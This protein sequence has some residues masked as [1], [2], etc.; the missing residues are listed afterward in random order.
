[1]N[2][3]FLSH[4]SIEAYFKQSKNDFVVDEVPLYEFSGEGEHLILKIRKKDLTTWDMV[5][6]ISNHIGIRN[7]EIGYAGLK[8]K[9]ALTVQHISIPK[10]Y[11]DKIDNFEH[12]QIKIIDKTYHNNKIRIGH[13][14]GN[15]FFI[16]LKRVIGLHKTKI[17]QALEQIAK[18][19]IPN[20]FGYQRFGIDKKNYLLG[21][22]I[23]SGK[24]KIR[25]RKKREF[26]ISAYQSYLFNKWLSKRVE[27][28]KIFTSFSEKE[29]L[30]YF[31]LNNILE[32]ISLSEIKNIKKQPHP[33]KLFDGD[34]MHHY[35][36]G[37]IFNLENLE[38][39]SKRF[40]ERDI[41]PTGLLSGKKVKI[42]SGLAFEFEKSFDKELK[43]TDGA[44]RLA[45]IYPE[46]IKTNYK[47]QN[48]W[49]EI[50]FYLPK[51]SYATTVLEEILHKELC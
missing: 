44:R 46:E 41:V 25:D 27:I 15:K 51:G 31:K 19:G 32:N 11:E 34:I 22:E 36:Y 4:S 40:I 42:S 21:E 47:E 1:M 8:D 12:S 23:E 17:E 18:F 24:L 2:Q 10:I 16:R 45:W 49:L 43:S 7:R 3:Y 28:S 13:L 6:I 48:A 9:N 20:Y 33:F 30:E 38:D 50:E 29:I 14:K 26:L 39:E 5:N 37:R 35:P